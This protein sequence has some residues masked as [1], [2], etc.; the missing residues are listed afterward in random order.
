MPVVVAIIEVRR[1]ELAAFREF[2]AGAA[3]IMRQHGGAI[4]K[5]VVVDEGDAETFTEIHFV[6]FP[7]AAAYA[8]YRSSPLLAGLQPL[9]NAAVVATELHV[10][11]DGPAY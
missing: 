1:S 4:E 6:R 2:E 3:A 8:A 5:T 7:D 11:E 10:G 9:R